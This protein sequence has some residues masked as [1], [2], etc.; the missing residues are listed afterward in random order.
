[1]LSLSFFYYHYRPSI[2]THVALQ[3]A[4]KPMLK[5]V[6]TIWI[7]SLKCNPDLFFFSNHFKQ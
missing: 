7:F 3:A 1:M 5:H 4:V 6:Q 2:L